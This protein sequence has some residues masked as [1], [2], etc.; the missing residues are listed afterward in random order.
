MRK[1][2]LLLASLLMFEGMALGQADGFLP[3]Q[4]VLLDAHNCYPYEDKWMDRVDQALAA[5]LP[6]GIE[7]DLVWDTTKPEAPRVVVRHG[8]KAKGNEPALKDYFFEKVR[9]IVE[10]ALQE[11]NKAQWPLVTLNINDLRA[12]EPEF[13][14]AL[15]D[16]V[17]HYQ[18]WI[19]TAPKS[20]DI[21]Q[22]APMDLKPILILTS[23]GTEQA[24]TFYDSVPVVGRLPLFAAGKPDQK[25][26]NFRR[27]LNYAWKEVEPE[28]QNKAGDWSTEDAARLGKLV[29]HA[30]DQGYWI[31][32][33]TLN[34]HGAK[35]VAAHG[36]TSSYNFGSLDSVMIRWK[37]AKR[38]GVDFVASDQYADCAKALQQKSGTK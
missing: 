25:A 1:Y 4:R 28:G 9:P 36:W 8:G 24:K 3:G 35:D 2:G 30:H 11:N 27:W 32:F 19:C 18:S 6:L 38:A 33:Y 34:G 23:D 15:W 12:N 26:D 16:L 20:A 13:F 31:R 37:A 14:T 5:G 10:K 17:N 7:M 22:I 21:S 29:Q